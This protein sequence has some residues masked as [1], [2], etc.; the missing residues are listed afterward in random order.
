[1]SNA[2][3]MSLIKTWPFPGWNGS[4]IEAHWNKLTRHIDLFVMSRGENINSTTSGPVA[5]C[6][7]NGISIYGVQPLTHGSSAQ[8]FGFAVACHTTSI[9]KEMSNA[10]LWNQ[11]HIFKTHVWIEIINE[12]VSLYTVS[13]VQE[14]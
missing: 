7:E 4:N 8:A 11:N 12:V 9:T 1:M 5:S 10:G 3:V 14:S 2:Y 13:S 6:S